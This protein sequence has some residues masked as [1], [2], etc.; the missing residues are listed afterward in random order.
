MAAAFYTSLYV[1]FIEIKNNLR[2]QELHR[3]NQGSKFLKSS[4]RNR[5]NKRVLNQLRGERQP[6]YIQN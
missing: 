1:S 4:F 3:Q 6:Q 5:D 2:R